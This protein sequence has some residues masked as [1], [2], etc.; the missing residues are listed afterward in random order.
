MDTNRK[1][2]ITPTETNR[3]PGKQTNRLTNPL[4]V[5]TLS[6][7]SVVGLLVTGYCKYAGSNPFSCD[8][9]LLYLFA[10]L[11]KLSPPLHY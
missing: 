1:M 6:Y 3:R 5:F 11:L 10:N 9:S 4:T 7:Y 2:N 8:F